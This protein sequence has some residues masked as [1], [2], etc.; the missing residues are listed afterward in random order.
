MTTGSHRLCNYPTVSSS[1]D[2]CQCASGEKLAETKNRDELR[3]RYDVFEMVV[4]AI[5]S[6]AQ[7]PTSDSHSTFSPPQPTYAPHEVKR[8]SLADLVVRSRVTGGGMTKDDAIRLLEA[9]DPQLLVKFTREEILYSRSFRDICGLP[10]YQD[11]RY[12]LLFHLGIAHED[13]NYVDDEL[14]LHTGASE[15]PGV[16]IPGSKR[17]MN[18]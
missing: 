1:V 7:S 15:R 9:C 2:V 10:E 11:Y 3:R 5:A 13:E 6:S 17:H 14:I 18:D 16:P 4:N 8:H 12:E